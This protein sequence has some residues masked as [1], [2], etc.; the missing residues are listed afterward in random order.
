MSFLFS[1][2]HSEI[3]FTRA[4]SPIAKNLSERNR[5]AHEGWEGLASILCAFTKSF[6]EEIKFWT[7]MFRAMMRHEISECVF[8]P[9]EKNL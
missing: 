6:A 7:P 8:P 1:S 4:D 5:D 3:S 9:P 2:I